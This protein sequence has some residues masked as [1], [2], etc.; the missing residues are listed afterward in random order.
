MRCRHDGLTS[1]WG[2][3]EQVIGLL[4][5]PANRTIILTSAHGEFAAK[6]REFM[7]LKILQTW[8]YLRPI[9]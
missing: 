5:H 1:V 8:W 9:D 7:R 4:E 6:R 3:N 2:R